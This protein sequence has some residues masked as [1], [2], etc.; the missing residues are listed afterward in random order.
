M[1]EATLYT[2][3]LSLKGSFAAPG[4]LGLARGPRR[5]PVDRRVPLGRASRHARPPGQG[6]PLMGVMDGRVPARAREARGS[7]RAR[8]GRRCAAWPL[9]GPGPLLPFSFELGLRGGGGS[10]L[11]S[12]GRRDDRAGR[13]AME[14]PDLPGL[15]P[16]RRAHAFRAGLRRV[17]EGHLPRAALSPALEGRRDRAGH[18]PLVGVR[19][20]PHDAGGFLP[21]GDAGTE[22]RH[23]LRVSALPDPVS[24][25]RCSRAAGS[26]RCSTCSW[27]L[28][29]CV[30]YLLLSCPCPSTRA[31]TSPTGSRRAP[32]PP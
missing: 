29:D 7:S 27:A 23:P 6:L 28:A 26:T 31:S 3:Q 32:P 1:Y 22:V 14:E 2:S 25:S 18:H 19:R 30:F 11:P 10:E 9:P 4:L 16:P 13:L 20:E 12:P 17:V 5:H 15:L 21:E 24:S 8:Y